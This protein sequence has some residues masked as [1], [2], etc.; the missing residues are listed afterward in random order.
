MSWSLTTHKSDA[1]LKI[2][3]DYFRFSTT[4]IAHKLSA[5][6]HALETIVPKLA[7]VNLLVWCGRCQAERGVR[8]NSNVDVALTRLQMV[9][10][11]SSKLTVE[12][13]IAR[14]VL[15]VNMTSIDSSQLD[16][17]FRRDV[18]ADQTA[19][20]VRNRDVANSRFEIDFRIGRHLQS[21]VD[22]AHVH[23]APVIADYI[24]DEPIPFLTW[25]Q[26][27]FRGFQSGR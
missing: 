1:A 19:S 3:D 6:T 24:Y 2:C 14:S 9:F 17:A 26:V 4:N 13:Y 11:V 12:E 27:G 23:A 15:G 25:R 20:N 16:I 21:E 22:V 10:A 8:R 18:G 7:D 5:I